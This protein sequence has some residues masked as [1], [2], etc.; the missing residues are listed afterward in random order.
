MEILD[1]FGALIGNTDRHHGNLAVCRDFD[2]PYRLLP[3]YDMLPMLYRPNAHGEVV[4]RQAIPNLGAQLALR[5]LP[6]CARMARQFWNEVLDDADIS[7]A[8]KNDVA[9]PHLATL[10]TLHNV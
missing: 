8:F 10:R 2:R 1:L 4:P 5:H 9:H 3:A 7:N 6:H